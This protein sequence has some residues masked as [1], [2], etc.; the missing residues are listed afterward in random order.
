M[1]LLLLFS[2]DDSSCSNRVKMS[3]FRIKNQYNIELLCKLEKNQSLIKKTKA[4][5]M[6][7]RDYILAM[8]G[9]H[10]MQI[11]VDVDPFW[12]GNLMI[13][14]FDNEITHE[15]FCWKLF[16]GFLFQCIHHFSFCV[17]EKYSGG[18]WEPEYDSGF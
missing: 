5:I 9:N 2:F 17:T 7:E 3:D 1:L 11:E 18:Y 16:S 8:K 6:Q 15:I 4:T 12:F 10:A 14:K 13:W